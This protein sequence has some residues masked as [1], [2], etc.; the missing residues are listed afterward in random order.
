MKYKDDKL[1]EV[2]IAGI[3]VSYIGVRGRQTSGQHHV[4]GAG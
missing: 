2:R 1:A 4:S 3:G